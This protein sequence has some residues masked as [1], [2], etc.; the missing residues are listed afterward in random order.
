[1]LKESESIKSGYEDGIFSISFIPR[2]ISV[3]GGDGWIQPLVASDEGLFVQFPD[4][5]VRVPRGQV[6]QEKGGVL[7]HAGRKVCLD[8]LCLFVV[9]HNHMVRLVV[10]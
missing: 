9:G 3:K 7:R 6:L 5:S 10:G 8:F 4:L 1:M 2:D